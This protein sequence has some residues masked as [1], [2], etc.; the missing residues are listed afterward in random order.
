MIEVIN[1]QYFH[2]YNEKISYIFYVLK[3]KHLGQLYYGERLH[4]IDKIQLEYLTK[5]ENK[6]AGTVK[7]FKDD[8]LFTL[9]DTLQVYPVFGTSDFKDGAIEISKNQE[10]LYPHFEYESYKI[11]D[12][13]Q[14]I[15]GLPSSRS[16]QEDSQT[17]VVRMQDCDHHIV[18]EQY[19]TIF[20][21]CSVIARH[22]NIINLGHE[23]IWVEK[24]MSTVL[25]L[26]DANYQFVHLSGAWLK[27][28]H[29][30]KKNLCQGTVSVGSIKGA[31]GHQHNPFVALEEVNATQNQGRAYGFHFI[32]SGNFLV[33]AEVDEWNR[34][35]MMIGIHPKAFAWRLAQ[36]ENFHTPEAIMSFSH[37]GTG[38]LSRENALFIEKHIIS[39]QWAHHPRPVVF[40][41]WEAA[42]FDFDE[43]KL[44]DL[45]LKSKELGMECFVID[46]GWFGHRD[47]D[48]SSLGDW[49]VDHKKFPSGIKVF[50]KKIHELDMKLGIWFEPEMIS[51]NSELYNEHPKWAV[52]HE[53]SRCSIGRG[54]YVIDFS[55]PEVVEY[56]YKQMYKIIVETQLDYIK[57]DMNRNITEAYSQYLKTNEIP[58]KEFFHR[59]ILGL[60]HLYDMLLESF[61]NLLIE[62]CAGG[63]GRFDLGILYYSPQ[64]WVSDDSDAVER[65]K[66]QFG[67]SLAYPMSSMSNHVSAVPNHQIDRIT[68]LDMRYHVAMFGALG[69]ELDLQQLTLEEQVQI[70]QQIIEYKS[71]RELLMKGHFYQ[72]M[73]PFEGNEVCWGVVNDDRSEALVGFYRILAKPNC[74]PCEYLMI[75]FLNDDDEYIVD[76]E[77]I[78]S[79]EIL[80]KI[81]IIQ[82]YQFNGAN[83]GTA[84]LKGDF[85]SHV[86]KIKKV[87]GNNHE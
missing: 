17:I 67:T 83:H 59:Y 13:H 52:M 14:P 31:S 81:G 73:S 46:D 53:G 15:P 76:N 32:Y 57:W 51:P 8:G 22:Q 10:F 80:R 12:G 47:N 48:R 64:I 35:R 33:Q 29:V 39:P 66:I 42:Y 86:F 62:G 72:L 44:Y 37:N 69:Y 43:N 68:S 5:K 41:S 19:F 54:Q 78:I 55:N 6:A 79:G 30:K 74:S 61:P 50:A 18:L 38:G 87:A 63:G 49:F 85:Q 4:H 71:Y 27:E 23:D 28:R 77:T 21:D 84:K 26:P 40:N 36:G 75:P 82:P 34:T 11:Y 24:A 25:D 3:N 65:L 45:A 9:G 7:F 20:K 56:I 70:K 60:Y 58:Q 1:H 16:T 2:L